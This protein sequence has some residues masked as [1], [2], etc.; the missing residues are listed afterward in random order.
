[1][2]TAVFLNAKAINNVSEKRTASIIRIDG[3]M[4]AICWQPATIPHG[5]T[6][7]KTTIYIFTAVRIS[8]LTF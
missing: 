6:T 8:N 1:M 2:C 7:H 5:V 4:E 3:K